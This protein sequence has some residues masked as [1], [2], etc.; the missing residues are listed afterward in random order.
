VRF[1]LLG[2]DGVRFVEGAL[3]PV[4]EG[5][6]PLSPLFGAAQDVLTELRQVS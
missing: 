4:V 3:D 1:Y 6:A 2:Y 5:T